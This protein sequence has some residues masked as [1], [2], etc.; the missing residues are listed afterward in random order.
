MPLSMT[1][2]SVL[3]IAAPFEANYDFAP[4]VHPEPWPSFFVVGRPVPGLLQRW[5]LTAS[6]ASFAGELLRIQNVRVFFDNTPD[7]ISCT[8]IG[9]MNE[10]DDVHVSPRKKRN[11]RFIIDSTLPST[12]E[13]RAIS[14]QAKLNITWSRDTDNSS[15]ITST[16]LVPALPLP[17]L[18]PRVIATAKHTQL[19][20]SP[21]LAS[22]IEGLQPPSMQPNTTRIPLTTLSLY[23]ENPTPHPLTF[24]ITVPSSESLAFSGPKQQAATLLPYS[25][26]DIKFRLLPLVKSGTW[27]IFGIKV[28]DRYYVREV[29]VLAGEGLKTAEGGGVRWLVE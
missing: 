27:V 18:E 17:P 14:L 4:Q 9:P 20:A 12:K 11:Y 23:L 13:Q 1:H 22:D 7:S 8:V 24:D 2:T 28:K 26:T 16:I 6:I 10:G 5:C 21:S 3:D 19:V 15:S 29:G 25:R